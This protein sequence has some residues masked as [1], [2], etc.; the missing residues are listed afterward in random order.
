[1]CVA[2][3]PPPKLTAVSLGAVG[4]DADA[5]SACDE[6]GEQPG[7]VECEHCRADTYT[8]WERVWATYTEDKLA[9]HVMTYHA[10][11]ARARRYLESVREGEVY[12]CPART[13]TSAYDCYGTACSET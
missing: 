7:Q 11:M 13:Y 5:V 4:D 3:P 8:P 10:P 9:A 12:A 1:V 2:P 6:E